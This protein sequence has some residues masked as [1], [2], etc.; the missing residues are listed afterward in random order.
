MVF[1]WTQSIHKIARSIT[2]KRNKELHYLDILDTRRSRLGKVNK[3][4][5]LTGHVILQALIS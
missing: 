1:L 2:Y 3:K 4:L 5:E